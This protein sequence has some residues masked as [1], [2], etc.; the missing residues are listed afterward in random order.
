MVVIHIVAGSLKRNC[1]E[2]VWAKVVDKLNGLIV[3]I[4]NFHGEI[5]Y[6]QLFLPSS[7]YFRIDLVSYDRV[8]ALADSFS[9]GLHD[10]AC[11]EVEAE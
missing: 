5:G 10:R 7:T 1:V 6:L 8:H 4:I 3:L 2:S 9:I 11:G